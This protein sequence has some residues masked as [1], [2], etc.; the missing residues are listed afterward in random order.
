MCKLV[1]R[2][3][4]I[5]ALFSLAFASLLG[6]NIAGAAENVSSADSVKL[7][8]K[9]TAF[10]EGNRYFSAV[11]TD[12]NEVYFISEGGRYLIQG[13]LYDILAGERADDFEDANK[14]LRKTIISSANWDRN[15]LMPV[16][17]GDEKAKRLIKVFF[18]E[19]ENG[20]KEL[21]D[22]AKK[23]KDHL[24]EF[25]EIPAVSNL[26]ELEVRLCA[27]NSSECS[28]AKEVLRNRM[29]LAKLA[30]VTGV[31]FLISE[32][33]DVQKGF[34]GKIEFNSIRAAR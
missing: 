25:V 29:M 5:S 21:V 26:Q 27:S 8:Q 16:I 33:G 13:K 20:S 19:S 14:L 23:N 17:Y 6:A 15:Q 1:L 10:P 28:R 3:L 24:F 11:T 4:N 32:E 2:S 22:F 7:V 9:I 34:K 30:G 12:R 18:D 31:P